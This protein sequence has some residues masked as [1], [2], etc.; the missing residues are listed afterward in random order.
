MSPRPPPVR[1]LRS[2]AQTLID[3]CPGWNSRMLARRISL[4]LDRALAPLG[5]TTSQLGLMALIAVTDDDTMGALATRAGLEQSTLSRNLRTLEAEGLIEIVTT[6]TDLR[7]RAVW[8]TETGARR[9]EAA[10]PAWRHAQA[11]IAAC[12]SPAEVKRLADST[13]SLPAT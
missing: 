6:E 11:Q 1:S 2:D 3:T 12:L 13:A 8:L 4:F 9:L 5:L 10:L 7:R